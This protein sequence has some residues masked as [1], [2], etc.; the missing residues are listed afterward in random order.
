[1]R[2]RPLHVRTPDGLDIS[3][4]DWGREAPGAAPARDVLLIHGMSQSH[5][6]W[7]R[8]LTSPL[9]DR[10]RFVSYD[11]RGHGD[12]DKPLST[13]YYR[14]GSR[15]AGEVKAVIDAAGLVQPVLVAWSYGGRVAL[16]YVQW[17]GADAVSGLVMAAAT[18]S[19]DRA[20]FG[21]AVTLLEQMGR[22]ADAEKN[23]EATRQFLRSC[24]AGHLP[25]DEE[26]MMLAY[27]LKVPPA[28][29]LAML[30]RPA[31][32]RAVLRA[33]HQPVLIIH[34]SEDRVDLPAMS[35]YTSSLCV[36]SRT[37]IYEGVGHS[38]FWEAPERF[39]ADLDAY[40]CGLGS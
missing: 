16:D 35:H 30:G 29:R 4:Q 5:Q 38:P 3:A 24:V 15:W 13:H 11:L 6:C 26:E 27:N 28:V 23:V 18:S 34:G 12:S 37:I 33:I 31:S 1:L 25:A 14:D 20:L 32:Y 2:Y 40:L 9:R 19:D 22:A 36:Q 7:L 21:T 17:A 39:N 8:Q 10:Y